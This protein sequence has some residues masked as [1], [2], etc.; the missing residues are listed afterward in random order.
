MQRYIKGFTLVELIVVITILAILGTIGYISF[1]GYN[2]IAR[3]TVRT[4]DINNIAKVVELTKIEKGSYPEVSNIV[5]VTFSWS[6]IWK[7]W[8]FGHDSHVEARRISE[9]P[10]DPL[11]GNEYAYSKTT[12]TNEYQVW[13]IME[14][15]WSVTQTFET[16]HNP[17]ILQTYAVDILPTFATSF[18]RGNYNG[19]FITHIEQVN[20]TLRNIYILWVPSILS[21]DVW[22]T[23]LNQ[24]HTNN[25]FVYQWGN[26]A[27]S[28]Y[29][30]SVQDPTTPWGLNLTTTDTWDVA[31]IYQ[32]TNQELSTGQ[33]KIDLVNNI[34]EYYQN[35]D[36]K[37]NSWDFQWLQNL[38]TS[39]PEWENKAIALVNSYLQTG[40][41]WLDGG[42]IGIAQSDVRDTWWSGWEGSGWLPS[43]L[44]DIFDSSQ[45]Y[46]DYWSS[47]TCDSN[48]ITVISVT[49]WIDKIPSSIPANTIYELAWGDYIQSYGVWISNCSGILSENGANIFAS[50][51]LWTHTPTF[52]MNGVNGVLYWLHIDGE[53][54]WLWG[55][56]QKVR[57]WVYVSWNNNTIYKSSAKYYEDYGI[58]SQWYYNIYLYGIITAY[59]WKDWMSIWLQHRIDKCLSFWNIED[60][61]SALQSSPYIS[62]CRLYNN[63]ERGLELSTT[64]V[65]AVL[66]NILS[67]NNKGYSTTIWDKDVFN[68]SVFFN[69]SWDGIWAYHNT[70][71]DRVVHN[72]V[73]F[74][75]WW[76]WLSVDSWS[77]LTAINVNTYWKSGRQIWL[78]STRGWLKYY[79]SLRKFESD[80]VYSSSELIQWTD[81]FLWFPNGTIDNT[82][83]FD[84]SWAIIP[85]V[86]GWDIDTESFQSWN[87]NEDITYTFGSNIPYQSQPIR[88]NS[89]TNSF[90][91]YGID[92]ID[93]DSSKK[94]GQW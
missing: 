66:N 27:P 74:K 8:S 11:T 26:T 45:P 25:S 47:N 18:V 87:Y 65:Q 40:H 64:W 31:I 13:A 7:Q 10:T 90:E 2:V 84:S 61:I 38:D 53:N 49:P 9:V 75:N 39:T 72:S 63:W 32:W 12:W 34:Q 28:T 24:I 76:E 56:H 22:D 70:T 19:K 30:W 57:Y 42:V 67:F 68:N 35:T 48:N 88:Y 93:Y 85:S 21:K 52:F 29:S 94:I 3:D 60:G 81:S 50:Q 91:L 41:G 46:D 14:R 17:L 4:S 44:A 20:P 5:N 80:S 59:N 79:G 55:T 89:G 6:T 73:I 36:I 83:T 33:G 23:T 71:W 58:R 15:L 62:N 82:G 37:D 43:N 1:L 77:P 16:P 69:N 78:R 86:I 51:F 54:D 92:G